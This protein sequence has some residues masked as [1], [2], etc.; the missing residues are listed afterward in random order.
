[1]RSQ[2]SNVPSARRFNDDHHQPFRL[3]RDRSRGGLKLAGFGGDLRPD[4]CKE[5][6]LEL[7]DLF[8]RTEDLRFPLFELRRGEAFGVGKRLPP[9]V[10]VRHT[11]DLALR[12]LDVI[13]E[14]VI[15][16]DL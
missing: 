3:R 10:I 15:E 7:A 5:L 8:F 9:F 11:G 14:D 6:D 2:T 12:D 1:M 13:A 4:L 16:P